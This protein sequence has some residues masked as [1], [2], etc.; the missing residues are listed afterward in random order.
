[1]HVTL[2]LARRGCNEFAGD[3][4]YMNRPTV[5]IRRLIRLELIYPRDSLLARSEV[6]TDLPLIV[7]QNLLLSFALE[8][9]PVGR[10]WCGY[11]HGCRE[12]DPAGGRRFCGF[13]VGGGGGFR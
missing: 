9:I 5:T 12:S 2:F 10:S 6:Q 1:M 11:I 4:A 7:G 3:R 13:F 8:P